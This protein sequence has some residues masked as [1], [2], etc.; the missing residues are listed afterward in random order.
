MNTFVL[1]KDSSKFDQTLMKKLKEK[2]RDFLWWCLEGLK[3][4]EQYSKQENKPLH[5]QF[6]KAYEDLHEMFSKFLPNIEE[7][8][9]ERKQKKVTFSE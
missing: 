9:L 4:S 1:C 3:Y 8:K 2:L 6:V 7:L 5:E